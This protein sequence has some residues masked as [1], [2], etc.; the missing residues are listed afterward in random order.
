MTYV[1]NSTRTDNMR[2]TECETEGNISDYCKTLPDEAP[3]EKYVEYSMCVWDYRTE[4][5]SRMVML[6]KVVARV[7]SRRT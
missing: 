4:D 5:R 3:E 2:L 7:S 6:M 1:Y